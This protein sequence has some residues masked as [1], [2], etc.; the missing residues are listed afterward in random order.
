METE[1]LC[2]DDDAQDL[3]RESQISLL[4]LSTMEVAAQLSM[5]DF[6]LFRNIE[7]TEYE[8]HS[9]WISRCIQTFSSI[10]IDLKIFFLLK[11]SGTWMTCSSWTRRWEAAIWNSLRRWSTRRPSG[12]RRRSWRSPIRWRGWRPLNTSS[13]SRCIA[14]S[15]RT[16]TLCLRLSGRPSIETCCVRQLVCM[17]QCIRLISPDSCGRSCFCNL[18]A[19][20]TVV[21]WRQLRVLLL[22]LLIPS[23]LCGS[24]ID[25]C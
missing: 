12:W 20:N 13:R 22:L 3:L 6:E 16:S 17:L 1:T 19:V 24:A 14:E 7:S 5:R 4:Q 9:K 21:P 8:E 15:A 18:P 11:L 25:G 10:V 2:S 23:G